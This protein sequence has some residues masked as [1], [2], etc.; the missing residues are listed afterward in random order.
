[1]DSIQATV[2]AIKLKGLD[3]WNAARTDRVKRYAELLAGSNSAGEA[4]MPS[5]FSIITISSLAVI[6]HNT[7]QC[8]NIALV[9]ICL[10]RFVGDARERNHQEHDC[11]TSSLSR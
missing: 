5:S 2:L 6:I 7:T 8:Y 10:V 3:A 11:K 9:P 1:M 4:L